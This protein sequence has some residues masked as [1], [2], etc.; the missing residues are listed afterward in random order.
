[1]YLDQ[2]F[3][4]NIYEFD[5]L[6]VAQQTQLTKVLIEGIIFIIVSLKMIVYFLF[7]YILYSLTK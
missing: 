3:H 5:K 7:F 6:S 4:V 2:W 1:M